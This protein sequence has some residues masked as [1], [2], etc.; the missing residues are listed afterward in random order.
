MLANGPV[1]SEDFLDALKAEGVSAY[2]RKLAAQA[3]GVAAV[4]SGHGWVWQYGDP[5][6]EIPLKGQ[7]WECPACGG[8]GWVGD[9]N[10]PRIKPKFRNPRGLKRERA[11]AARRSRKAQS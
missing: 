2:G 3:L 4:K 9:K 1:A 8:S 11:A 5:E 10:D 7:G 6:E